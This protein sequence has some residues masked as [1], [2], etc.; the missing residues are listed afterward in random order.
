MSPRRAQKLK[1]ACDVCSTSKVKCD[2]QRPICTRCDKF[3]YLCFYSLARRKGRPHPLKNQGTQRYSAES[4]ER[5][6]EDPMD[7]AER[8]AMPSQT[9]LLK[10]VEPHHETGAI[11]RE[12]HDANYQ[13]DPDSPLHYQHGT[14]ARTNPPALSSYSNAEACSSINRT[15]SM[16]TFTP[17][18]DTTACILSTTNAGNS[19]DAFSTM[20]S[21]SDHSINPER[22]D[23][24]TAAM[25]IL[26]HLTTTSI[27]P[28]P[29]F[30]FTST[31]SLSSQHHLELDGPRDLDTRLTTASTA[32]KR[33]ST[34]LI[35][36][37]SCKTDVGLLNAALCGAILDLYDTIL[38]SAT[39]PPKSQSSFTHVADDIDFCVAESSLRGGANESRQVT[40]QRLLDELP[41][42]ANLVVQFTRRYSS[43]SCGGAGTAGLGLEDV[44]K[45]DGAADL[46][47][48]A[49]A[50]SQ[51]TRLRGIIHE[52]TN[53]LAQV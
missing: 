35:C 25:N 44:E 40:I 52:A 1:D 27:Q 49:L 9:G 15:D 11:A 43:A 17:H 16:D 3:G 7:A 6:S 22:S 51:K 4:G 50:V 34:I 28:L 23:C 13:Q 31:G 42:V 14:L 33:L 19:I 41:K 39:D 47:L 38:R 18:T 24:A 53:W 21:Y 45:E 5:P 46:L 8:G 37:C 30:S 26:Q 12:P 29:L 32:I 36:P 10:S 2:K 20:S 48:P